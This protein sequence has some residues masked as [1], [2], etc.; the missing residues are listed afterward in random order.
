MPCRFRFGSYDFDPDRQQLVRGDETV[1][2][3]GR[4][5]AILRVLAE[6][7][8]EIVSSR[9]LL[10]EVWPDRLVG[11]GTLRVHIASLRRLLGAGDDG[12]RYIV[13]EPGRGYRLAADVEISVAA[14]DA[15]AAR[16]APR[17]MPAFPEPIADLLGRD[18][19]IARVRA[20]L[21]GAPR[22][23]TLVGPGGI[24]KTSLAIA[25]AATL[26]AAFADGIAFVDLAGLRDPGAIAGAFTLALGI[27]PTAG[28][29]EAVVVRHLKA[30]T[31]LLVVDNCEHVIDRT[32]DLLAQI[33]AECPGVGILATS[34]E[35]L[36]LDDEVVHPVACLD[37]PRASLGLRAATALRYPAVQ[38]FADRARRVQPDFEMTDANVRLA[39]IV[40][41]KLDGL[42]LAIEIAAA[43]VRTFGLDGLASLTDS[44]LSAF[45]PTRRATSRH[46]SLQAVLD[47]SVALLSPIERDAFAYLSV[48]R[49]AFTL[50]AAI[51]IAGAYGGETVMIQALGGLAEK[52]LLQVKTTGGATTY[53]MLDT[54]RA[55]AAAGLKAR[56]EHGAAARRHAAHLARRLDRLEADAG[57]APD[58]NWRVSHPGLI[59]EIRAALDWALSGE[60]DPVSGAVLT[61]ASAPFWLGLGELD[62]YARRLSGALRALAALPPGAHP[63]DEL[64]RLELKLNMLGGLSMAHMA[65]VN[66]ENVVRLDR[67][68]DLARLLGD[69]EAVA[70]GLWAKTTVLLLS[71]AY[72]AALALAGEAVAADRSGASGAPSAL[73]LRMSGLALFHAGRLGEAERTTRAAIAGETPSAWAYTTTRLR[74]T[75]VAEGNLVPILF[76]TG[77]A[78][79]ARAVMARVSH[80]V[81]AEGHPIA[82][83]Y[84]IAMRACVLALWTGD[85]DHADRLVRL[86]YDKAEEATSS[87][88]FRTAAMFA[89]ATAVV[90]DRPPPPGAPHALARNRIEQDFLMTIAPALVGDFFLADHPD[91]GVGWCGAEVLRLQGERL[92][93]RGGPQATAAATDCFARAMELADRQGALAWKLRAATSAARLEA[94]DG[95]P[96][97]AADRLAAVMAAFPEG[98][99]T[100]DF[101]AA[102]ALLRHSA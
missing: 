76:L 8:G 79:A 16:A 89:E 24:G 17:G 19:D 57:L 44:G 48:F 91:S 92:L 86:L 32:A 37:S 58:F 18:E 34:R 1:R 60:G 81:V 68:L 93:G 22:L 46:R 31:I 73:A 83:Y 84:Q 11:D 9:D 13:N 63:R 65:G 78:D 55:Y 71:G 39:A 27:P 53:R 28:T 47:W 42:P 87:F 94:R 40:C 49:S 56:G 2:L 30:R 102:D 21:D 67:A 4:A 77:R 20:L 45:G 100:A 50:E 15:A 41:E 64:L 26:R 90:A 85:V 70:A 25:I 29:A 101:T 35:A 38:L 66:R 96:G 80:T 59:H 36:R 14:P 88:L 74:P 10:N 95:R 3:S 75:T 5:G 33:L 43:H 72:E 23:V 97:A 6:R 62:E 7:A 51:E 61:V 99:W 82:Y 54:T 12:E 98:R 69:G 52:S